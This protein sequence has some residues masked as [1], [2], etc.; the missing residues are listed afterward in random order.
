MEDPTHLKWGTDLSMVRSA[1]LLWG[2]S[3][4]TL[5]AGDAVKHAAWLNKSYLVAKKIMHFKSETSLGSK[6]SVTLVGT[7]AA[8]FQ[9]LLHSRVASK[10]DGQQTNLISQSIHLF[11]SLFQLRFLFFHPLDKHLSHF[12]FFLLKF[13]E[14]FIP[15]G[16]VGFLQTTTRRWKGQHLKKSVWGGRNQPIQFESA[17]S[18]RDQKPIHLFIHAVATILLVYFGTAPSFHRYLWS[19]RTIPEWLAV[20]IGILKSHFFQFTSPIQFIMARVGLFAKIFH[21]YPD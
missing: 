14:K 11:F 21:V 15:F 1:I 2:G 10:W 4:W 9:P 12:L 13:S 18:S 5:N 3:H 8:L 7:D 17:C 19:G 16:L 20:W 6:P